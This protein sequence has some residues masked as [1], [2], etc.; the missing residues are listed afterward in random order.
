[1]ISEVQQQMEGDATSRRVIDVPAER[2]RAQWQQ[3]TA[4]SF[5]SGLQGQVRNIRS[6]NELVTFA[7]QEEREETP[8]LTE[9]YARF[10]L[11]AEIVISGA[12]AQ[13]S[14]Y[15]FSVNWSTWEMKKQ[16]LLAEVASIRNPRERR[17]AL[18]NALR[19][20]FSDLPQYPTMAA[21]LANNGGNDE[22]RTWIW[23]ST[24]SAAGNVLDRGESLGVQVFQ[25][26]IIPVLVNRSVRPP[27]VQKPFYR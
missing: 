18:V 21:A 3:R 8:A 19:S 22:V 2:A 6:L 9:D 24:L 16:A 25:D 27:R 14:L 26:Q 23:L 12:S 13:D 20:Q 5:L 7:Q 17:E 15:D 4:D 10:A 1:M 11:E